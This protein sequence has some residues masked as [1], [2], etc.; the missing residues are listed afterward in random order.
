V[1][2]ACI[3]AVVSIALFVFRPIP[4]VGI[5][6]AISLAFTSVVL[7]CGAFFPSQAKRMQ[8]TVDRELEKER[9]V[10]LGHWVP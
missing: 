5:V 7:L 3:W 1:I 9:H 10:N 8:E 6:A 2:F 4:P